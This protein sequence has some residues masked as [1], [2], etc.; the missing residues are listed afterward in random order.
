MFKFIVILATGWW[1][2]CHKFCWYQQNFKKK[3]DYFFLRLANTVNWS[4]FIITSLILFV[5]QDWPEINLEKYQ[6]NVMPHIFASLNCCSDCEISIAAETIEMYGKPDFCY[7]P[8]V[9]CKSLHIVR[10]F[11]RLNNFCV[12]KLLF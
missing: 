6:C 2:H 9:L 11:T 10:A 12:S 4:K 7:Y 5:T 1:W 3:K 8:Q